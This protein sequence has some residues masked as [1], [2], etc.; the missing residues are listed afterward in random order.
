MWRLIREE[1]EEEIKFLVYEW[2]NRY[3]P[4]DNN[5]FTRIIAQK[6]KELS[7]YIDYKGWNLDYNR[8]IVPAKELLRLAINEN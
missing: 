7:K 4:L 5:K 3:L 2:I 8:Y 6:A 1:E